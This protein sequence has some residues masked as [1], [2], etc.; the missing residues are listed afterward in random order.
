MSEER[1]MTHVQ[2]VCTELAPLLAD[3]TDVVPG[4]VPGDAEVA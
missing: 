4:D 1:V 3:A 2:T